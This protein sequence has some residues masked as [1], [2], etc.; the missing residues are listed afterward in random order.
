M[1]R[2]YASAAQR[3]NSAVAQAQAALNFDN[4]GDSQAQPDSAG[5]YRAKPASVF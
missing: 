3:V 5:S 1:A 2:G 4:A